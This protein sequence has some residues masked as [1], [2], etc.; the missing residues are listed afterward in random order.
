M[1]KHRLSW[2]IVFTVL[3]AALAGAIPLK[4]VS[5]EPESPATLGTVSVPPI[6]FEETE[7]YVKLNDTLFAVEFHKDDQ[8]YNKIYNA[9]GHVLV[10]DERHYLE[11]WKDPAWKVRGIP[12]DLTWIKVNDWHYN[13][14]RHYTD[15][16]G[17]E[18]NI[19]FVVKSGEPIKS[20]VVVDCG[21]TDLYRVSWQL[22]GVTFTNNIS[23]VNGVDFGSGQLG[24]YWDDVYASS[25]RALDVTRQGPSVIIKVSGEVNNPRSSRAYVYIYANGRRV[26]RAPVSAYHH[27]TI[28]K[29]IYSRNPTSI[30]IVIS[31]PYARPLVLTESVPGYRR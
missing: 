20:V 15:Y 28:V 30:R 18:W 21:Q 10:Y 2:L 12:Y 1:M 3:L 11:Y 26:M 22:S 8:G 27:F 16:I 17:T 9:T 25:A 5:A 13:V 24:I 31:A 19:T 23:E 6:I 4:E 29:R 7:D 14:T